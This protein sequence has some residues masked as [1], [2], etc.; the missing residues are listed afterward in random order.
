MTL[1]EAFWISFKLAMEDNIIKDVKEGS[2]AD[3]F[4]NMLNI[5][6][7]IDRR[8]A[9]NSIVSPRKGRKFRESDLY[10]SL[11]ETIK[12]DPIRYTDILNET[13]DK[14]LCRLNYLKYVIRHNNITSAVINDDNFIRLIEAKNTIM[15]LIQ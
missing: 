9:R 5:R 12:S 15:E 10:S 13:L 4:L 7:R 1:E 11:V 3:N 8:K 2:Y 6:G 14:E